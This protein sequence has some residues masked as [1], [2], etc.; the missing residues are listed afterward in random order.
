MEANR[1]PLNGSNLKNLNFSDQTLEIYEGLKSFLRNTRFITE[2]EVIIHFNNYEYMVSV[3][4]STA[5]L[6]FKMI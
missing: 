1:S 4:L 2:D 5:K 6:K 3:G